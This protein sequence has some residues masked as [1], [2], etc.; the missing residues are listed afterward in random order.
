MENRSELAATICHSIIQKGVRGYLNLRHQ[1][2]GVTLP[3]RDGIGQEV[4]LRKT[5]AFNN[6]NH[7][8][9]DNCEA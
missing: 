5:D 2:V 4:F 3:Q 9:G 7:T 8:L 6:N 1:R